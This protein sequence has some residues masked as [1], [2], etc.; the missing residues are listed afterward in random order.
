M[1]WE[2]GDRLGGL[3]LATIWVDRVEGEKGST[4]ALFWGIGKM[5]GWGST[6]IQRVGG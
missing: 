1:C 6:F 5:L 4:C 2:D 3:I